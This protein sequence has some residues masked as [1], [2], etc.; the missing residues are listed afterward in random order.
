MLLKKELT[1]IV[2]DVVGVA[3]TADTNGMV[4]VAATL[5]LGSGGGRIRPSS[6]SSSRNSSSERGNCRLMN[7]TTLIERSIK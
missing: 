7:L 4:A 5:D 3:A 2:E 6:S 1:P